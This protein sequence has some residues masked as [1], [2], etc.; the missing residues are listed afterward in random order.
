MNLIEISLIVALPILI[1]LTYFTLNFRKFEYSY[2]V[3]VGII[4]LYS[5]SFLVLLEL[6]K[7]SFNIYIEVINIVTSILFLFLK[8]KYATETLNKIMHS[9]AKLFSGFPFL[10]IFFFGLFMAAITLPIAFLL[11]F[12]LLKAD[13][14]KIK[15]LV[16]WNLVA[17]W[18][19]LIQM[20]WMIFGMKMLN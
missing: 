15:E 19:F 14:K 20:Y 10:F 17:S 8:D 7:G 5:I 3:V 1:C 12:Y 18:L 6:S 4:G 11:T 9:I 13:Y 2:Y 16:Y